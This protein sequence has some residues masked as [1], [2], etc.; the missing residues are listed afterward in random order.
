MDR[1]DL[2]LLWVAHE[3]PERPLAPG[4]WL[5]SCHRCSSALR[6]ECAVRPAASFV[7][8]TTKRR[9]PVP[10]VALLEALDDGLFTRLDE[11]ERVLEIWMAA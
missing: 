2:P 9:C 7:V 1:L 6:A 11:G 10:A 8:K 4:V 3:F 5:C